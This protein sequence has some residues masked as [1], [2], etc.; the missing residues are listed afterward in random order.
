[1]PWSRTGNQGGSNLLQAVG[2]LLSNR[3]GTLNPDDIQ[4]LADAAVQI[5]GVNIPPV[6]DEQAAA[7]VSFINANQ[8]TTV[9]SLEEMVHRGEQDI[10]SIVIP[11]D[12]REVL[13]AI[14]GNIEQYQELE[15]IHV[16]DFQTLAGQ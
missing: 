1:M 16:E 4:V 3:L 2:K 10:D 9:E 12:V 11:D 8:I 7:V 14:A 13:E 15:N 5:G 6:T